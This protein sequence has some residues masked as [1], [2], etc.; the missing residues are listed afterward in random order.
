[1]KKNVICAKELEEALERGEKKYCI[2]KGDILTPAAQ[3]IVKKN[4]IEIVYKKEN[5]M[6]MESFL[7]IFR[8]LIKEG[9]LETIIRE[10]SQEQ[11]YS[12]EKDE[13][14]LKIIRGSSIKMKKLEGKNVCY[15]EFDNFYEGMTIGMLHISNDCLL[16][17]LNYQEANYIMCGE[18][19][20][21]IED[22]TYL[23][24]E[25]DILVIP[26]DCNINFVAQEDCKILYMSSNS[27][28]EVR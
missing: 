28:M 11:N 13:S 19:K 7:E 25:G 26:V 17:K 18:L 20:I 21:E 6:D 2:N 27:N 22:R 4:N 14:G 1:M 8:T 10:L 9:M 15:R 12:L 16:R 23:V 24:K 3:D 5:K